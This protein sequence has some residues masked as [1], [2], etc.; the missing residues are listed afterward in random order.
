[1]SIGVGERSSW[2]SRVGM[3]DVVIEEAFKVRKRT[4]LVWWGLIS[5]SDRSGMFWWRP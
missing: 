1:M 4:Q 2:G 5:E 3:R